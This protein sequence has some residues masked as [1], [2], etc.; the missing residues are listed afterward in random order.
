MTTVTANFN[1]E[2]AL[3]AARNL[4]LKTVV[5]GYSPNIPIVRVQKADNAAALTPFISINIDM[6]PQFCAALR[7]DVS[8]PNAPTIAGKIE[9]AGK[10][11]LALK[12]NAL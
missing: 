10:S 1:F 6:L 3:E 12:D 11:W 5:V 8:N 2:P 7:N 9:R 4:D